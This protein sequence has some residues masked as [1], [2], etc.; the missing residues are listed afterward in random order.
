MGTGMA[1][2]RVKVYQDQESEIA[3]L[4]GSKIL[5]DWVVNARLKSFNESVKLAGIKYFTSIAKNKYEIYTKYIRDYMRGEKN[6]NEQCV[7]K[8]FEHMMLSLDKV[9]ETLKIHQCTPEKTICVG[10]SL[11]GATAS[12]VCKTVYS[13]GAPRPF[14]GQCPKELKDVKSYRFV[15]AYRY[16]GKRARDYKEL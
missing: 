11:G 16:S 7:H 3:T 10:H 4:R 2:A 8:G 1:Y 14:C 15:N 9:R 5:H 13:I 12:G 6:E